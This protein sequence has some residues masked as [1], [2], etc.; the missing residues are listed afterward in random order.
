MDYHEAVSS[1]LPRAGRSTQRATS[2]A[3]KSAALQARRP[4]QAGGQAGCGNA[5]RSWP[6]TATEL[7][8]RAAEDQRAVASDPASGRARG[9]H[10]RHRAGRAGRDGPAAR[11]RRR[12]SAPVARVPAA[13]PPGHPADLRAPGHLAS[14]TSWARASTRTG[15]RGVVED[16]LRTGSGPRERRARSASSS[17]AS[18]RR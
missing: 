1:D 8:G 6:R 18:T 17:T 5:R 13:L 12:Q 10:A 15:W 2:A 3:R 14:T 4:K 16:F 11:R 9:E 7:R